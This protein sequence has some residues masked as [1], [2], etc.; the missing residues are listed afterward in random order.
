[1]KPIINCN[2]EKEVKCHRA[3]KFL[4][5]HSTTYKVFRKVPEYTLYT[6]DNLEGYKRA[7]VIDLETMGLD[8][9]TCEITE[10][11][12]VS[13]YYDENY[14]IVGFAETYNSLNDPGKPI[15]EFI[16]EL[17]GITT[18]DVK[19]QVIDW[20][21]VNEIISQS[22]IIICH[23][24][25][26]DRKFLEV[27]APE[28]TRELVKT[29]VFGCTKN[30]IDW[31]ARGFG[32]TKLDYLNWS[33]QYFYDAHRAVNDCWATVNLLMNNENSLS[34]LIRGVMSSDYKI[35]VVGNT[36]DVKD[37]LKELGLRWDGEAK[38]WATVVKEDKLDTLKEHLVNSVY[39]KQIKVTEIKPKLKYSV[40]EK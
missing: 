36:Y 20:T 9:K 4:D 13:F 22:E 40:L 8:Y 2:S 23:N 35:K 17:T 19:G 15:P 18:E 28:E 1:M 16:T 11:G 3:A 25:A 29:K 30:D 6:A 21:L 7:T 10:L 24:S 14:S 37:K 26:F 12:L 38:A 34:E 39:S 33:I 32:N 31:K 27:Q 5:K